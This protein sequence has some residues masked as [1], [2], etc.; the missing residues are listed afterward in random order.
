M[1][2]FWRG[3]VD[4]TR[5]TYLNQGSSMVQRFLQDRSYLIRSPDRPAGCT[6]DL[7]RATRQNHDR[8]NLLRQSVA[9][10]Y[11]SVAPNCCT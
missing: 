4:L 2:R 8:Q 6:E 9:S 10:T 7:G 11:A 3:V 1:W 5:D